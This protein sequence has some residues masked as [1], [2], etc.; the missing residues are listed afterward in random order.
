ME[1]I[2]PDEGLRLALQYEFPRTVTEAELTDAHFVKYR[3]VMVAWLEKTDLPN[4]WAPHFAVNPEYRKRYWPT[5]RLLRE[6]GEHAE[7][8][9]VGPGFLVVVD[10]GPQIQPYMKRLGF[11]E[12]D[13][14]TG[15]YFREFGATYG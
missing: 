15:V 9:T 11:F 2:T 10:P 6:L 7:L 13:N 3:D 12:G 8:L 14:D 1:V 4:C 5:K